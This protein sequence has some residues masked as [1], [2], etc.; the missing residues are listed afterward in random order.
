MAIC[1]SQSANGSMKSVCACWPKKLLMLRFGVLRLAVGFM[2][3]FGVFGGRRLVSWLGFGGARGSVRGIG[4]T[5]NGFGEG[6][7]MFLEEIRLDWGVGV[8]LR[9]EVVGFGVEECDS[10][11]S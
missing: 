8:G 11:K 1:L 7:A 3:G 6:G 10:S 5:G 9:F 2:L 4:V